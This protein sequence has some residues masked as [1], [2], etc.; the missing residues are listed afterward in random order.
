MTAS[1]LIDRLTRRVRALLPAPD[2]VVCEMRGGYR[3]VLHPNADRLERRLYD[4]RTYEPATL[5]L[6][7]AVLRAGDTVVDVGAN[8]G[9]M[10]LHA[11]TC[12]G[13]RGRVIAIEPHPNYHRRLVANAAL[14]GLENVAAVRMAAGAES[15]QSTLYDV[16]SVNIGRSSLI[17]PD[18]PHAAA[19][20]VEVAPLDAILARQRAG[21]VRV[22]KIDVEGFELQVLRGARALL[23]AAPIVCMEVTDGL[24]HGGDAPL[25][26]HDALLATGLFAAYVFAHGKGR[27][28]PLVPVPDRAAL[29]RRRDDNLVYVPHALRDALPASLFAR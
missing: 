2:R 7:D 27:A 4:A 28:S 3:L 12:V 5:A 19:A 9:L 1:H 17:V 13:E 18:A 26:A 8:I 6:F 20:M 24:P 10:T 22:L 15:G 14:N 25:A 23:A 11:A 29:A 21:P 16:P